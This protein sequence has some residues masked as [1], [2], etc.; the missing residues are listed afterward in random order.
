[1]NA[2]PLSPSDLADE[3]RSLYG[4]HGTIRPVVFFASGELGDVPVPLAG[5]P[6]KV[7][8]VPVHSELELRAGLLRP[9]PVV[10][11]VDYT[12][13]LPPDI[14]ARLIGRKG[15]F[16]NA[17]G[18][19][20]RKFSGAVPLT[21]LLMCGPL[22]RA[23]LQDRDETFHVE[24]ASVSL[25]AAFRALLVRRAG[26]PAHGAL[27]LERVL[28]FC[29]TSADPY[30]FRR[31]LQADPELREALLALLDRVAGKV[32][33]I[34]WRAWERGEGR[35]AAAL[36]LILEAT[37]ANVSG[38]VRG[39]LFQILERLEPGLGRLVASEPQT[40]QRWAEA[41][42]PLRRALDVRQRNA[43]LDEAA[44]LL[45]D[46]EAGEALKDSRVLRQ[47]L[48]YWRRR[49]GALLKQLAKDPR[50]AELQQAYEAERHI[51]NHVLE[52]EQASL[53]GSQRRKMALRLAGYM[54]WAQSPAAQLPQHG[55]SYE[56][57]VAL[58]ARYAEHGGFVDYARAIARSQPRGADS[59]DSLD[60]AVAQ[61]VAAADAVRDRQDALFAQALPAWF[62]AGRPHDRVLPIEE[63]LQRLAVPF[64]EASPRRKLLVLLLDGMSWANAV[65]IAEALI[66]RPGPHFAPLRWHPERM[67]RV[68]AILAAL[69]TITEVSRSALF[70]GKLPPPGSVTSTAKD[71]ERFA[72]HAGLQKVCPRAP[73]LLLRSELQTRTGDAS[74]R[75]LDL[76]RSDERVVGAVVNAIDEQLHGSSQLH[77]SH[78]HESIKP[79]EPL[80]LAA[81]EAGRAILL[82]A[83]HGHITGSRLSHTSGGAGGGGA[84]W[85]PLADKEA[86]QPHE[87]RFDHPGV[88]RPRGKASLAMLF[89]ETDTYGSV[90]SAGEHGGV[91]LAEVVAPA[92]LIGADDLSGL[93]DDD[94]EL[95]VQPLQR[96]SWWDL[97]LAKT[98]AL[99]PGS[100]PLPP[101]TTRSSKEPS[102]QLVM[103]AVLPPQAPRPVLAVEPVTLPK[104]LI[105]ALGSGHKEAR[106][107][108]DK[109]LQAIELLLAVGGQMGADA[110]ANKLGLLPSRVPGFVVE[111]D[112]RLNLDGNQVVRYD[113][114]GRQVTL[115]I[116]LLKSL[117]GVAGPS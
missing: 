37:T 42:E 5:E 33:C 21:D 50:L 34:A 22:C 100:Q 103:P 87:V 83:D 32:A 47:S 67:E 38:Y 73:T 86:V 41:A 89:R 64:L 51:S 46:P 97:D 31:Q 10:L 107:A 20:R 36:A 69:P 78:D 113:R 12:T 14:R 39:S 62:A 74:S 79:L 52:A 77:V 23:L 84:R 40:L 105:Q 48:G 91:S 53:R 99:I 25:E 95:E 2:V 43:V 92:L 29:A 109:A 27:S 94:R 76:V 6:Q 63:V 110:F 58:A 57:A 115:S 60:S 19:L 59:E 88:W 66:Q 98:E 96:P 111:L 116:E 45:P 68:P 16:P 11:L 7:P 35:K 18:R 108:T 102:P 54:A 17:E 1:M 3:L 26:F 81:A 75:A 90:G 72:Q 101:R 30:G 117:Y 24:S 8:I 56:A 114:V 106:A 80:L 65:E 55:P 104:A 112:E 70:A 93:L 82:L 49:L 71:P 28:G 61:V 15:H 4:D 9:P 85:R 13:D 44:A